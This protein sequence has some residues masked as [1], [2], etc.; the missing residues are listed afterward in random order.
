MDEGE[1]TLV[2][3]W[4]QTKAVSKDSRMTITNKEANQWIKDNISDYNYVLNT[5]EWQHEMIFGSN[6]LYPMIAAL[7]METK[8]EFYQ[9]F[10]DYNRACEELTNKKSHIVFE[11][12]LRS[13]SLEEFR[14]TTYIYIYKNDDVLSMSKKGLMT[15]ALIV[16]NEVKDVVPNPRT[17]V[18]YLKH[19]DIGSYLPIDLANSLPNHFPVS[20]ISEDIL[21]KAIKTKLEYSRRVAE[22]TKNMISSEMAVWLLDRMREKENKPPI[23]DEEILRIRLNTLKYSEDSDF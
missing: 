9:S 6:G 11:Y 18:P 17:K 21:L 12:Y 13:L 2:A 20:W 23:T 8:K 15:L 7:F 10:E 1:A 5:P 16:F 4:L 19:D 22:E 14:N 3:R